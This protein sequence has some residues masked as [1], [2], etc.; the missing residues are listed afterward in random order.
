MAEPF[1]SPLGFTMTPALSYTTTNI[2]Q[3]RV[4]F[5]GGHDTCLKVEE[6]TVAA[7]PRFALADH[8]RRHSCTR[9]E[10]LDQKR[11]M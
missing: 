9:V 4:A 1:I 7:A 11:K 2:H 6:E 3:E 8:D 10:A 5:P